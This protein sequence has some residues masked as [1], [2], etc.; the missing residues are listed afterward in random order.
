MMRKLLLVS[1]F[2]A[3]AAGCSDSSTES[4]VAT[5]IT[6]APAVSLNA[7]GATQVVR[8]AVNDQNG[9]AMN[10]A[11]ITWESSSP[12]V[13]VVGAGGDSAV[14]TA[15]ANGSAAVT[16]RSGSA[17]G[18]VQVQVAQVAAQAQAVAGDGQSGNVGL[19][20]GTALGVRV[21]D[22]LG[23]AIVGQTVTFTVQTGGGSL[24]T[25]SAVTGADGIA[26]TSLT[27]GP[28]PGINTVAANFP[29]TSL[30]AVVFTAQAVGRVPGV[31]GVL[32]GGNRAA[33]MG[34]A[35]PVAP[36]VV[37]RSESGTPMAGVTV[38]FVV[39]SG[40]GRVASTSAVTGANGVASAGTWTLGTVADGNT[41][42][43]TAPGLTG[44]PVVLR[45]TG[46]FG[47]PGAAYEITLCVTTAMTQ[48]QRAAFTTAAARWATL[49]RNDL[50]DISTSVP[51]D[52]CG[53]GTPSMNMTFD[54]LVIF[55]AV[56]DIDGPGAVLG[57]AGPC[58]VRTGIGGLP[59]IG[60]MEF[61]AADLVSLENSNQLGN[62]I[63]HEMGHVLGIGTLWSSKGLLQNRSSAGNPLDTFYSGSNGIVG[64]DAIGG[65]SY[66]G[67]AKVPVEN[68]G[69]A[70]TQNG[71]WRESVL[72]NE[73]MTGFLNAGPNPLSVLTV[74]SL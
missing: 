18:S 9:K 20:L 4:S 37:A 53:T 28:Q 14:V 13:T 47:G 25:A 5:T 7:V 16:A 6:V 31:L 40:G 72:R 10:G 29:G 41:L 2:A 17:S 65:S 35:V 23:V 59:V 21:V 3:L 19:A 61:D 58:F 55:A 34:T 71:H 42:T 66:T 44:P 15:A 24:S 62:V 48:T 8:A 33:M 51:E 1:I 49:V 22:R 26:T 32:A 67:G 74:R 57:Q 69:G 36:A 11:A 46:C 60:T 73:L 27:L 70:G 64:F 43:A 38:N 52:A 56:T 12:S 63:L 54:D 39:T 50:A 30:P 45:A 68:T